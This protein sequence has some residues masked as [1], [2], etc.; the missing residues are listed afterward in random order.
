ME[1][2]IWNIWKTNTDTKRCGQVDSGHT[3]GIRMGQQRHS[4]TF[5]NTKRNNRLEW[6]C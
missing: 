3:A 4:N 2:I 5:E 6:K 1:N